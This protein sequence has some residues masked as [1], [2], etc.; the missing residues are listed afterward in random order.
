MKARL[1]VTLL[2]LMT[3]LAVPALAQDAGDAGGAGG[4]LSDFLKDF[5]GASDKLL[6]LAEAMSQEQ[7]GYAASEEV[8]NFGQVLVHVAGANF[9]LSRALGVEPPAELSQNME[10]QVTSKD[11][12]IALLKKSQDHVRQAVEKTPSA[13]L[14]DEIEI[15]GGKR[16]VRGVFMIIA[17]HSHEHLGQG[18]AYARGAGVAPPWSQGG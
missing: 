18:I 5:E 14:D 17:G 10:E 6:Q 3:C 8:R 12:I 15:F 13:K 9:F 11:E 4:Y 16:T 7:Y 1:L 2:L